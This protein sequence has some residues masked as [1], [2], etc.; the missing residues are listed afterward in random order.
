MTIENHW[1]GTSFATVC[2]SELGFR[3]ATWQNQPRKVGD[4]GTD[5]WVELDMP[6]QV[7]QSGNLGRNAVGNFETVVHRI[8]KKKGVILAFSFGSVA[9]EGVARA[10][11]EEGLEIKF[12]TVEEILD[13]S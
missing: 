8:G 13:E 1:E 11:D 5:G 6:L 4:F 12:K 2:V 3:E 10:H 9:N 7:N